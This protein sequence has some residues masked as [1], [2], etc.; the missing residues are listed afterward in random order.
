MH[1][2]QDCNLR[3][4]CLLRLLGC[5]RDFC[6]FKTRGRRKGVFIFDIEWYYKGLESKNL[7]LIIESMWNFVRVICLGYINLLLK[8]TELPNCV[9][10]NLN[11]STGLPKFGFQFYHW[12][13][14]WGWRGHWNYFQK[15][16]A[17]FGCFIL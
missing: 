16:I 2:M 14:L 3:N 13:I 11:M 5:W 15:L 4:L 10:T 1:K 6:S 7:Y 8:S 12:L 9:D 17:C